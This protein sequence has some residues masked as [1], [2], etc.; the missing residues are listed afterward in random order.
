MRSCVDSLLLNQDHKCVILIT[1]SENKYLH[2]LG[3]IVLCFIVQLFQPWH[4]ISKFACHLQYYPLQGRVEQ[5]IVWVI[6]FCFV[7]QY[8]SQGRDNNTKHIQSQ[9]FCGAKNSCGI[10]LK[11]GYHSVWKLNEGWWEGGNYIAKFNFLYDDFLYFVCLMEQSAK[12]A[13]YKVL[14]ALPSCMWDVK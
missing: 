14:H 1:F 12:G 10:E 11:I 2:I 6:F 3:E 5:G 8:F 4:G 9:D 7:V 13:G